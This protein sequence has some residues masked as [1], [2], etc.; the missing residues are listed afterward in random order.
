MPP[1]LEQ[2]QHGH[3][4]PWSQGRGTQP[5]KLVGSERHCEIQWK[6]EMCLRSPLL[7]SIPSSFTPA[8]RQA[9]AL[10]HKALLPPR[11]T[12]RVRL[13]GLGM[14][15]AADHHSQHPSNLSGAKTSL[16]RPISLQQE[17]EPPVSSSLTP[18]ILSLVSSHQPH[19][20]AQTALAAAF[21]DCSAGDECTLGGSQLT[22]CLSWHS[23][24]KIALQG[25]EVHGQNV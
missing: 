18:F 12:G 19:T 15:S 4:H 3:T 5:G 23:R 8:H 16:P 2:L 22:P 13:P 25:P 21:L 20:A 6:M 1:A 24:S 10:L 14:A 17:K 11:G 7:R 9:P